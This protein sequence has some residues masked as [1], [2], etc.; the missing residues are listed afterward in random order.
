VIGVVRED[1]EGSSV[2]RS[3]GVGPTTHRIGH[4]QGPVG[5]FRV[6]AILHA[7][8]RI[9]IFQPNERLSWPGFLPRVWRTVGRRLTKRIWIRRA[10]N[11]TRRSFGS[12]ARLYRAWAKPAPAVIDRSHNEPA[13]RL[14]ANRLRAPRPDK[15]D[16]SA[17]NLYCPSMP[18]KSPLYDRDFFAWS[19]EQAELLRAG[20]LAQADIEHIAEEIDSMGRTEKRELISRLSVLL[21]HLLKWRYQPDKRSPSWEASIRVQ[22]NRLADHLDDNPS[23]KPLLPQALL[24]AYRDAALEAVAETGLAGATFPATCPWTV[25]QVMDAGFWPDGPIPSLNV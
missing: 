14:L 6:Q 7:A 4:A 17:R 19:R 22:C 23:L 2:R 10:A 8:W 13:I 18:A 25:D 21:L 12:L 1:F 5:N 15:M 3:Q 24:S 9:V 20:K 11:R 16:A